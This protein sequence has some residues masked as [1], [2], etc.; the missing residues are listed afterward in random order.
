MDMIPSLRRSQDLSPFQRPDPL[1]PEQHAE[2]EA[3]RKTLDSLKKQGHTLEPS[4]ARKLARNLPLGHSATIFFK[5]DEKTHYQVQSGKDLENLSLL[6]SGSTGGLSQ[7]TQKALG[8]LKTG[9]DL[10]KEYFV[11]TPSGRVRTSS[12][13]AVLALGSG[14]RVLTQD[15]YGKTRD[16]RSL[17]DT[18][19]AA[20]DS[21]S[22]P[23]KE[24]A[25]RLLQSAKKAGYEVIPFQPISEDMD[26]G[27]S[28]TI[29]KET[30]KSLLFPDPKSD[31]IKQKEIAVKDLAEGGRITVLPK[32]KDD[33]QEGYDLDSKQLS[34]F[35]RMVSQDPSEAQKTFAQDFESLRARNS[36]IFRRDPVG[37]VRGALQTASPKQ[38]YL[39]L[40]SGKGELVVLNGDGSLLAFTD[41]ASFHRYASTGEIPQSQGNPADPTARKENLLAVYFA[42]PF[43][44]TPG[45][46]GIY[47]DLPLQAEKVGSNSHTDLLIERS[48]LPSKKNL[49]LEYVQPGKTETVERLDPKIAMS[50]PKTL[51][52][53]VYNALKRHGEDK[54]LRLMVAGHGGAEKGLIPDGDD[55]NASAH[56]AMGVDDFALA[57]HKGLTRYNQETGKDRRIDNLIVGSCLMGNTSFI[58]ALARYGDVRV[59]NASPEVLMGTGDEQLFRYLAKPEGA[60]ADAEKFGKDLVDIISTTPAF[61]GGRKNMRNAETYGA[62]DLDPEKNKKVEKAMEDF[63]ASVSASPEDAQPIKDDIYSCKTYG[64]NRLYNILLDV[65][66]RD[67]IEVAKKIEGDHRIESKE[68]RESAGRLA[69]AVGEQVI[70]QKMEER[71]KTRLGPT[72]YLPVDRYDFEPDMIQTDLL[73]G[74]GYEKFL[75]GVFKAPLYRGVVDTVLDKIDEIMNVLKTQHKEEKAERAKEEGE[76]EESGERRR[77]EKSP[78]LM[79]LLGGLDKSQVTIHPA[80]EYPFWKKAIATPI[81]AATTLV[82]GGVGAALGAALLA[83][84]GAILGLRAGI[85]GRSVVHTPPQNEKKAPEETIIRRRRGEDRDRSPRGET[86]AGIPD[87]LSQILAALDIDWKGVAKLGVQA[88]LLPMEAVPQK[89]HKTIAYHIGNLPGKVLGGIT[90]LVTGAVG[91]ALEGIIGGGIAGAGAGY[92]LGSMALDRV[93]IAPSGPPVLEEEPA[94]EAL[95]KK[96]AA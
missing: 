60:S 9:E 26:I 43:D 20:Q 38:V 59:L 19:L 42:S 13:G 56:N 29:V 68:I 77:G 14:T 30:L 21:S 17:K 2:K 65:D 96:E 23:E 1:T 6:L 61:P 82:L 36:L 93:G 72:I 89:A 12:A 41:R 78:T 74:T 73:K 83:P 52:D 48:D 51:E 34:E 87:S 16:L 84:A 66:E 63:F 4:D 25:A 91:G 18:D 94:V 88:A 11:D 28:G 55:N 85:T 64:M 22:T 95:V 62:Y 3:I 47:D 31:E 80:Q 49:L 53:F 70:S 75:D 67:L 37:M 7:E 45:K 50:D 86:P 46:N 32:G 10:G 35:S 39:D 15:R 44:P 57:I 81:K 33:P 8:N 27:D 24:E 92:M 40:V 58:H 90:G 54:R 76:L 5:E 79:D 69:A 71:Y